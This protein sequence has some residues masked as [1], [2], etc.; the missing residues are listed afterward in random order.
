MNQREIIVSVIIG[1]VKNNSI[2]V[3]QEGRLIHPEDLEDLAN[4]LLD[5]HRT[6]DPFI[7]QSLDKESD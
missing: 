4:E 6:L 3:N 7:L 2:L 5:F 1:I